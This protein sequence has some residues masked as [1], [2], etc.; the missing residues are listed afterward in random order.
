MNDEEL[1]RA[2]K[3]AKVIHDDWLRQKGPAVASRDT[4][5][6]HEMSEATA[7]GG[8][9]ASSSAVED[10]SRNRTRRG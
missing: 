5:P 1:T 4:N 9:R 6:D 7:F 8:S 2:F 10:F 3:D